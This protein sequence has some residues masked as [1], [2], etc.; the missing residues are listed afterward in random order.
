MHNKNSTKPSMNGKFGKK[1][2]SGGTPFSNANSKTPGKNEQL[3]KG[4]KGPNVDGVKKPVEH[5]ES[6]QTS[7]KNL[8]SNINT[9]NMSK[10]L[11][12]KLFEDVMSG[13]ME[14]AGL[15]SPA[16]GGDEFSDEQEL[17]ID[18]G[19]D[20]MGGDEVT[21]TLDRASAQKFCDAL[22]AVLGDSEEEDEEDFELGGEEDFGEEGEEDE[23]EGNPFGEGT[24]IEELKAKPETLQSKGKHKVEVS[25][26]FKPK[27]GK[28]QHAKIPGQDTG[29]PFTAKP[30]TLQSKGHHKV[31][32]FNYSD[33]AFNGGSK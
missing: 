5:K 16:G 11:F 21:I 32:S 4:N 25:A 27:G 24:D 15:E 6:L 26:Q 10:S 20:E 14:D 29:S 17:G 28:A 12:D 3:A 13:G 8:I 19:G 30:E 22:H 9:F 7:K 1:K 31:S 18:V 2:G 33:S 23:E